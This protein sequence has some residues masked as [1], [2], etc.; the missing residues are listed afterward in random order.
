MK[1]LGKQVG[2]FYINSNQS[3]ILSSNKAIIKDDSF[4]IEDNSIL[5]SPGISFLNKKQIEEQAYISKNIKNL[6]LISNYYGN[7]RALLKS[8]ITNASE[9]TYERANNSFIKNTKYYLINYVGQEKNNYLKGSFLTEVVDAIGESNIGGKES[10]TG[11]NLTGIELYIYSNKKMSKNTFATDLQTGLNINNNNSVNIS[12]VSRIII[13]GLKN[14]TAFESYAS[15]GASNTIRRSSTVC[16]F[17]KI[18]Y[19]LGSDVLT[20]NSSE[21]YNITTETSYGFKSNTLYYDRNA[22]EGQIFK[23]NIYIFGGTGSTIR[24]T[25]EIFN[26]R[27]EVSVFLGSLPQS[28][29]LLS[30]DSVAN[31]V[32]LTGNNVSNLRAMTKFNSNNHTFNILG[33]LSLDTSNHSSDKFGNYLYL[34]RADTTIIKYNVSSENE[35]TTAATLSVS[36]QNMDAKRIGKNIYVGCY[37]S[38]YKRLQKFNVFNETT[39]NVNNGVDIFDLTIEKASTISYNNYIYFFGCSAS[40]IRK[41]N[42]DDNSYNINTVIALKFKQ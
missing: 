27:T 24:D 10:L 18:A 25:Y 15:A 41:F 5:K 40:N 14:D 11:G 8:S 21:K 7:T 22:S 30:S 4:V 39:S 16:L 9:L 28:H 38:T 37:I 1:N 26:I 35:V 29:E 13:D 20:Y 3:I 2:S 42:A 31:N 34:M 32:Y 33:N 12:N 6:E 17:G 19:V 23:N 36:A